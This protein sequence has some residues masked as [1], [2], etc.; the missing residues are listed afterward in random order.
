[1]SSRFSLAYRPP[2]DWDAVLAF[3]SARA[4]PGVE[5]VSPSGYQRTI[6]LDDKHGAISVSRSGTGDA[7]N[8]EARFPD[9]R[10]LPVI[11]ERVTRLFDLD[12]DSSVIAEHLGHDPLLDACL[13]RH[14]GIRTPGAWDG[15]ELAVRAIVGQQISVRGATTIAGRIALMFG[16]PLL[17]EGQ[18]FS[19]DL[20]HLF[21]SPAQLSDAPIEKAG[22][23]AA[24]AGAIRTLAGRVASGT[25]VFD[26]V[27]DRSAAVAA[28][29]SIPG[30]GVWTA[31]YI[32][33][34]ALGEPDAF[35]S[36]DVVLRRRAGSVTTRE[37][38]RQAEVWR[39]WRSYAVMLL[40]QSA[41][42]EHVGAKEQT[43][44]KN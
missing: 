39:P 6:A 22:V 40:W 27:G 23:I 32:A 14:P 24:R 9:P 26:A 20:T 25:I 38:D 28:L 18:G 3:L 35:P 15:F 21:P 7:V 42:D 34:R 36:G 37:L 4:T 30:I 8:L 13:R 1:M 44:C 29:K 43:E 12:A 19:P 31:Q 33:M 17:V 2:Y 11:V 41:T 5:C 16:S 10:C